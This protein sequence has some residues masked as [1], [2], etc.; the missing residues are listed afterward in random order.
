MEI[1]MDLAQGKKAR[2]YWSVNLTA[3][4]AG[5]QNATTSTTKWLLPPLSP[6]QRNAAS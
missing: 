2:R 6:S 1:S 3:G 4:K 5:Y